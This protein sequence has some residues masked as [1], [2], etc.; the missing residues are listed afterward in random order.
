IADE[1]AGVGIP[2]PD[3]AGAPIRPPTARD[4]PV[5]LGANRGTPGVVLRAEGDAT[6]R[7]IPVQ[8]QCRVALRQRHDAAV[9]AGARTCGEAAPGVRNELLGRAD[10]D[11]LGPGGVSPGGQ[12]AQAALTAG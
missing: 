1:Q 4:Y 11:A 8:D 12:K 2:D 10:P 5:P 9:R 6:F 7:A 3:G